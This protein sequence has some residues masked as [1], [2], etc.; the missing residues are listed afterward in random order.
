MRIFLMW[1]RSTDAGR[2]LHAEHVAGRLQEIFSA[3]FAT[4]PHVEVEENAAAA[5]VFLHLPVRGWKAS[6]VQED[7][8]D[9]AF[10]IDYPVTARRVLTAMGIPLSENAILPALARALQN[11]PERALQ[12][13]A[14]PC[15]LIWFPRSEDTAFLQLDGLAQ[16]QCF[17]YDDGHL[18]AA[19]NKITALKALGVALELDPLDWAAK[20][21][22]GW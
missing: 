9:R 14:P 13:L 1:Q 19:T 5:L 17:E 2:A 15:S 8:A 4:P 10:A 3:L 18:W 7:G 16:A 21:T 12:E 22:Y 20:C 11:E 6:F